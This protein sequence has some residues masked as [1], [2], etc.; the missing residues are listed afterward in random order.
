MEYE[1]VRIDISELK[2]LSD[3]FS[4]KI[5]EIENKIYGE[6]GQ[7]FNINSPKQVGEILFEKMNLP[8]GKK[9]RNSGYYSTD[10]EILDDLYQKGF[11]IAG[12]ILEYRHYMKLKS[13]YTDVLPK[14]IDRNGRVHTNYSNTYVITGRLSSSGPNLQN[15]PIRTEDG[16]KIRKTFIARDG[17]SFIG[18]DYSQIELRILAQY[19]NVA[20]LL[21][22]FR[23]NCDIHSET[24]KKIFGTDEVTPQMRRL[25]KTINFSIIY[26]TT[27]YGLAKRLTMSNEEAKNYIDDYFRIY[28]EVKEYMSHIKESAKEKGFVRTIFNRICYIDLNAVREPQKSF[29]ERLTINAPIQGTGADIIKKAMIKV[30]ENIKNFDAKIILQVHDELLIEVNDSCVSE[31]REIVRETME[32]VVKFKVPFP[33]D[34][35]VGKNWNEAH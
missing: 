2:N 10:T 18:A 21:E 15:I 20:K 13:T 32:N 26:G 9:S 8:S 4:K 5:C 6:V 24:A 1:G 11:S 23:K 12:D 14:L 16:E 3:Y 33:V 27:P 31:V 19:A 7:E 22:D 25:A 35:K 29:L 34:I 28:P 30:S 17:F